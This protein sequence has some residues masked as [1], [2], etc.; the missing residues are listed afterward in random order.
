M[1]EPRKPKRSRQLAFALAISG[2]GAFVGGT[3]AL[4]AYEKPAEALQ[5]APAAAAPTDLPN[6]EPALAANVRMQLHV[7]PESAQASLDGAPLAMPFSG[8]FRRDR[9]LHQLL[10][11]AEGYRP[12]KQLI[13]FDRDSM[14]QV[15]LE[16]LPP[17]VRRV[18]V[19]PRT[20]SADRAP[21]PAPAKE[22]IAP[23]ARGAVRSIDV[24][25]PYAL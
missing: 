10:V 12:T 8:E 2:I 7:T 11:K 22:A 20:A 6:A 25:D 5:S 24:D 1:L 23:K 9:A 4:T 19:D 16:K 17:A 13:A 3:L 21:A 18:R 14:L 15:T